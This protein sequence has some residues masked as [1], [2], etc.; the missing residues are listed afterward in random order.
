M[1]GQQF[2]GTSAGGNTAGV[3]S[4]YDAALSFLKQLN[5]AELQAFMDDTDRLNKMVDDLELV[6]FRFV[7]LFECM[8]ASYKFNWRSQYFLKE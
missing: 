1:Y 3:Q 6:R 2:R 7:D 4:T 8:A 5:T